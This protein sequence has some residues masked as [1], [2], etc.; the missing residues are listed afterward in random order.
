[1]T[2]LGFSAFLEALC[3]LQ[4]LTRLA[5]LTTLS[6]FVG[7]GLS[8][9]SGA[10][11]SPRILRGTGRV[12]QGGLFTRDWLSEGIVGSAAWSALDDATVAAQWSETAALLRELL[13]HKN[14]N[15]AE[16]EEVVVW[17]VIALLGWADHAVQQNMTVKGR[18]DVPDGLLFADA[19]TKA[20]ASAK[21]PW[22]R[23]QHGLCL[24]EAKRWNRP[25]D[26]L[27]K[28][29]KP[30]EGVPS[31]QLMHYLRRA[32]DVTEGKLRWG[33][34]T[35]GRH[36][37]LYWQGALSVAE[38]FIEIDLGRVLDLPG[39]DPDLFESKGP[40][41]NHV[42]RLFLLLFGRSAFLPADGGKTFH[43]LALLE[44]K[45]W[46]ARVA[47]DL[48]EVVFGQVFPAL[49]TALAAHDR[50]RDPARSTAYLEEVR[51]G[52]L[53]LLYRL[54]FV[55]YAEDRNLLPDES[56]PYREYALS[57]IR[58]EIAAKREAGAAFSSKST[59]YW[60]RLETIFRAIGD[61]DDSLG[62]PPYNGGLFEPATAP[63]L[64][65][66]P[67]PDSVL[68]DIIF[69]LSHQ[70]AKPRYKYINY[71]DLSVQQL[72]SIYEGILEYGVEAKPDGGVGP[73]ADKTARK[74][75]GSYYTPEELVDLIIDKAVGPLVEE[76]HAAF[77]LK[78]KALASD[79]RPKP[80][81]MKE[82]TPL[83]PAS[84]LLD[85]KVCDPAMGSGHFLVSLVDWLADRVLTAMASATLAVVWADEPYVSPL[86]FRIAAIRE[87]ILRQARAHAWPIV[88]SQLD[89]RHIVRRMI[90]KRVVYGVDK[91]PMAVE[92]AKVALWL[93]SFTVGAPL[94]FL[95]HHLRC[96]DS[97]VGA[98]V[99]PTVDWINTYNPLYARGQIVRVEQI[100]EVMSEIEAITDND[101]AEVTASKEKFGTVAEVTE[102]LASFFSLIQAEQ[103]LQILDRAPKRVRETAAD[104][105]KGGGTA[106]QIAKAREAEAA[107]DRAAAYR[108]VLEGAVGD[109]IEIAN[110][111]A[112]VASEELRQQL[113][114]LPDRTPTQ[115][116]LFPG[117][118]PDD[119]RRLL[120]DLLVRQARALAA[121]HRFFH[122]EIGFP[123]V[124]RHLLHAEP[125]GGFDA[126][127]GNPPY[128]RQELLGEIKPALKKTYAAFD[129]MADL[130]VYFYEQGLKLL[131][132]GGRMAYVVT[133]KWLK[134]G[135]AENLRGVFAERGW[136]EFLADFG[137]AKHFF[138][139]ADVFPC[140][141]SVRKPTGEA[142]PETVEVCVV[143]RDEVPEI[144]LG[145][146]VVK[147]GYKVARATFGRESWTLE[148]P[149]VMALLDKLKTNGVPLVE[150]AG[151]KPFRGV[152]TGLNEAFLIDTAKRDQLVAADPN[153][154]E[155]IKPYLRGQDVDRWQAS[156][157]G[158]W[159][160][161]AR[162][163]IDIDHYRPVLRHLEG[164][165]KQLEPKPSGWA[166]V[167]ESDDWP[168]RKEG[169]YKWFEIQDATDY[170][171]EFLKPKII[172]QEIQYFPCY[173]LD[174]D[175]R[176]GNNKTF[177]IPVEDMALLAVLNSPIMWWHN[178]RY[179]PHMKDEA[180]SPMGYRMEQL[181]I[182]ILSDSQR[183]EITPRVELLLTLTAAQR[184]SNSAIADWLAHEFGLARMPTKLAEANRLK[185][186]AFVAAV[187]AALPKKTG[188][189]AAQI[190]R[191]KKEHADTIE[192]ARLAAYQALALERQISD[193]VN[194]AYG[195][196][197]EEVRLMW[198]TA[199]PR[200]PFDA[201]PR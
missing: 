38:D 176:F 10:I 37:R 67:L 113:S 187:R 136:V 39:C 33:I 93:H 165:R 194:A 129:G 34:L 15:E 140:V 155:I 17:P 126:V 117:I 6:H 60:S 161:F 160:I 83:D 43:D 148:P 142:A 72:G 47:K 159:M 49:V 26:R 97:I 68:A 111:T 182:P 19:K 24:V 5:A 59:L 188:L 106:M 9:V 21:D 141:I 23:F 7:E 196:T 138:P 123:N 81:R 121:R 192:P 191:L 66:S 35:N 149:A 145:P 11:I 179:L 177:I 14:P 124:W 158:L 115:T 77:A 44:G 181:P 52:A 31:T 90:L 133:N 163:G 46:E 114:L 28:R 199:P 53:I 151:V 118:R 54:L 55:L 2:A 102:P 89:D 193:L 144:G 100:A 190:A 70:E 154:A 91:N 175:G 42:F 3:T 150:Y 58:N 40:S 8:A 84:R 108:L 139:D 162:R 87:T 48:S 75:S 73:V 32:D 195:L 18:K 25:L 178:W 172:Y 12:L 41:A 36:W 125:D 1:L 62:I 131:R 185:A 61:G 45:Q 13:A 127:I 94:S 152:L 109:P 51:A 110:G 164:Y 128:V 180:L 79:R 85:I 157:E 174:R 22:Q 98:W 147:A 99:R 107:F 143:P 63:I 170:W 186:D 153:C 30:E 86:A 122:W 137:H 132:P 29:G 103:L 189:S 198:D 64:S 105:A 74:D 156:W 116:S 80:E 146:A 16:T 171:Q 200:M 135:Y 92:L 101:I 20:A 71:R 76:R 88:E 134:A 95:D 201:P 78:T 168:G 120:A 4:T 167:K 50:A 57:A 82:L 184:G 197:A 112:S 183:A 169:S 130:Y 69:R 27:D 173:A 65:R 96:G 56:G 104:I 119:R 166:P